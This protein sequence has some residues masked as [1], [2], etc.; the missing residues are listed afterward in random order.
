IGV[1]GG[2]FLAEY[3][4]QRFPA[5]VRFAADVLN[6]TPSIVFGVVAYTVIVVPMHGFSAIAGGFA[7][8]LIMVPLVL[9]TTEEMLRL[10]PTALRDA[11]LALGVPQYRTMLHA[12]IPAARAGILTGIMLATAR[13]AGETA[14]LIFTAFNDSGMSLNLRHAI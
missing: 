12:V 7:L 6:G 10:V 14:P 5:V 1:L 9:R 8:A 11:S 2:I 3:G 13:I 4:H